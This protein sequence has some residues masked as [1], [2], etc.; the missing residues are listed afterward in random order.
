MVG[1]QSQP[2]KGGN[3]DDEVRFFRADFYLR[4]MYYR[5]ESM[6]KAALCSNT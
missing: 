1:G 5:F 4:V 6:R 2:L 3:A